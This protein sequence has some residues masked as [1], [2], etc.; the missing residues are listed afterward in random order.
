MSNPKFIPSMTCCPLG[1]PAATAGRG[2]RIK[3]RQMERAMREG[4]FLMVIF[5]P[6]NE[7]YLLVFSAFSR[8]N[9]NSLS[10]K[11]SA[12]VLIILS[13]SSRGTKENSQ[14]LEKLGI[15]EKRSETNLSNFNSFE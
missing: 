4:I 12:Q 8:K 2:E 10:L 11:Q 13:F 15:S 3:S 1:T 6:C 9:F 14:T 5:Y 7:L